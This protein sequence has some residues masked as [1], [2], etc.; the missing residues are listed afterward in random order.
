[1]GL[2]EKI[3]GDLDEKEVKKVSK[4]ADKVM[5]YEKEMEALTDDQLCEKTAEF[6]KRVQE[7]GESLDDIL[8]EA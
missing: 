1:M 4:I 2:M 8:P 5:A 7:D 3:F 6:K